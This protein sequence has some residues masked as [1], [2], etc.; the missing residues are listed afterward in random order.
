MNVSTDILL[1]ED[2]PNDVRLAM[3]VFGKMGLAERCS[4]VG[5]GEEAMDFL[6]S[7]G[8]F[9]RR[10]AVPPK[11]VLL[12]LK[13]P[14]MDGFQF[15]QYVRADDRLGLLPVVVLTSSREQRDVERAY[16]LHAN[17]YVVKG[18][19]FTEYGRMLKIVA[20]YWTGVNEWKAG[21]TGNG[22]SSRI[23]RKA[24]PRGAGAL[25]EPWWRPAWTFS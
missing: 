23:N 16:A 17:G 1:V 11:L 8:P 4:A 7:R 22:T 21:L 19:S 3:A 6:H 14:R 9:E 2:D 13:T 10:A 15:L 18:I 12:D 24:V 20:D 25:F 5:D